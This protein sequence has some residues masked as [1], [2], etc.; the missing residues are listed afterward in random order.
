MPKIMIIILV[1]IFLSRLLII[2]FVHQVST[3]EIIVGKISSLSETHVGSLQF[4]FSPESIHQKIWMSW[5]NPPPVHIFVG[6]IWKLHIKMHPTQKNWLLANSFLLE[7]T[8]QMDYQNQLMKRRHFQ[9]EVINH[10]REKI[11]QEI[12]NVLKSNSMLGFIS[13]LT[14][15]IRNDIT[16]L[17][18]AD[19]RSTGTNHLM[20][21]AGLH[22]GFMSLIVY[23][24][25]NF[26]W[27][28]SYFL[29]LLLPAQEASII[30]SLI[31][32]V[33]YS[34][35]AGFSLPTQRALSMLSVYLL[36][37]LMRIKISV[38]ESYFFA[39]ILVL[40]L[41]PLSFL[42]ATF[43][44][45][46][47]AVGLL[48]YGHHGRVNANKNN[49][50]KQWFM[51]QWI[52]ALGLIPF[53]LLF[54]HQTTLTGFAANCIA[55]PF[56]GFVILPL[57]FLGIFF[58]VSWQLA[59]YLLS[60]FWIIIHFLATFSYTQWEGSITLFE[61]MSIF[62]GVCILL[63]P[64]GFPHRFMGLIG[65]LPLMLKISGQML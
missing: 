43:W 9:N 33:F 59:A 4:G 50:F 55:I 16:D 20:A 28:R 52:M 47:G 14:V 54:F 34:I 25:V 37:K 58:H 22:I 49:H 48:I 8:V 61:F 65:F 7:G 39:M 10:Y 26:L 53:G 41:A 45:S 29:L 62:C 11:Y 1:C 23:Q 51:A 24:C 60:H 30:A 5:F 56:V 42:S 57:C 19:L 2:L 12:Q 15:G 27:R 46:F 13:A 3:D 38:L 44:L 35:L 17:Q 64:K 31:A 36:T 6:D 21:I 63:A 32:A 40:V 18:W